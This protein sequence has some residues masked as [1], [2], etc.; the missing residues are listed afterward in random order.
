MKARSTKNCMVN[1][2]PKEVNQHVCTALPRYMNRILLY[3]PV[4]SMPGS[5]YHKIAEQCTEWLSVVEECKIQFSK[6][7]L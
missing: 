3:D 6:R 1:F 5:A 2:I 7:Y 4:M